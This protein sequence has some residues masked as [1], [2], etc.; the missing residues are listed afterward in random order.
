V[1]SP[2]IPIVPLPV[3]IAERRIPLTA[4]RI[5][6]PIVGDSHIPSAV[7]CRVPRAVDRDISVPIHRQIVASTELIRVATTINLGV[8]SAV[9]CG[10]SFTSCLEISLN[11]DIPI[12]IRGGVTSR[13]E[14]LLPLKIPLTH[15]LVPREVSFANCS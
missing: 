13:T 10:V 8:V 3:I 2:P 5:T 15:S 9:H 4:E 1:A 6:M 12:S 7:I 14:L 11:R